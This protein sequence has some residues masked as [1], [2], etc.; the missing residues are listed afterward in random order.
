M[1]RLV[2]NATEGQE[3]GEKVSLG[4]VAKN[5]TEAVAKDLAEEMW[6]LVE[7]EVSM[8]LLSW[9]S[10]TCTTAAATTITAVAPCSG[11]WGLKLVCKIYF[12]D[13]EGKIL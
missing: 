7:G 12:P 8:R 6:R 13:F 10:T 9:T 2:R 11:V 5:A 1:W 4:D 3:A